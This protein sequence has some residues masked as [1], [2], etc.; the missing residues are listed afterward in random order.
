MVSKA[1]DISSPR[2]A[3]LA[4]VV[5]FSPTDLKAPFLLRCASL[6]IDYIIVITIPVAWLVASPF[7]SDH[8]T[9]SVSGFVWLVALIVLIVDL[10]LLPLF[11]GQTIGKMFTGITIVNSDGTDVRLGGIFRRNVIGYLLTVLTGGLGFLIAGI[12]SS[13]RA[14]HDIVGGTIVVRGHK[15]QL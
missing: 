9:Q 11:R 8:G 12:N 7:F 14:L 15:R 6:C 5:D 3:A 1:E 10:V 13:G 4:Q 2:S